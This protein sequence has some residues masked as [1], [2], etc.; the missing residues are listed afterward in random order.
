MLEPYHN[1]AMT[2]KIDRWCPQCVPG[3]ELNQSIAYRKSTNARMTLP[4]PAVPM[5]NEVE[6]FPRKHRRAMDG[7]TCAGKA[8]KRKAAELAAARAPMEGSIL[9]G[10]LSG[11]HSPSAPEK[12]LENAAPAMVV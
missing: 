7:R 1:R 2:T 12:I 5:G 6:R 3:Y 8:A 10:A 11:Q 9:G 4:I